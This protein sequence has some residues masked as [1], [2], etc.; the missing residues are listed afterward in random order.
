MVGPL[1]SRMSRMR[2]QRFATPATKMLGLSRVNLHELMASLLARVRYGRAPSCPRRW[3]MSQMLRQ[4]SLR[5]LS[6]PAASRVPSRLNETLLHGRSC[7]TGRGKR[8]PPGS[9]R[10]RSAVPLSRPTETRST[11]Y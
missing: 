9:R 2:T 11:S 6:R 4:K 10:R 8:T 1:A 5:T 7:F 3:L